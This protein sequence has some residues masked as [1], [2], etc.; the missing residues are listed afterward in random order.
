MSSDSLNFMDAAQLLAPLPS[1]E[2]AIRHRAYQIYLERG[3][4]DG[5]AEDDWRQAEAEIIGS[6]LEAA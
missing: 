4:V 1:L 5:H 3:A 6:R 2:D